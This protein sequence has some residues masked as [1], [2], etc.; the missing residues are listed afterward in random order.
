MSSASGER[1]TLDRYVFQFVDER[2][3]R[4]EITKATRKNFVSTLRGFSDVVGARPLERLGPRDVERW[5]E[6]TTRVAASTRRTM[7][8]RVKAFARWL[9]ARKL[10]RLDLMAGVQVPKVPRSV[11]RAMTAVD[12]GRVVAMAP[13]ARGRAIVA[14]LVGMGLR[15][16]EVARL[17]SG[18]W[19][20]ESETV[21]VRG[22]AGHERV[23]PVPEIVVTALEEYLD[24]W[25][26]RR[27]PLIRSYNDHGS[28]LTAAAISRY[29]SEWMGD[30]GVKHHAHDGVSAHA[31]RHTA[32]SDVLDRCG[33]LRVVQAMLGHEH[34]SST[35]IYLRRAAIGEMREAMEGR[36]YADVA[37]KSRSALETPNSPTS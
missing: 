32:A 26:M 22:K 15:C 1:R 33:D 34:L 31:L 30:A 16:V 28:P 18:D 29:V 4:G 2:A 7:F 3:A 25:P 23:L 17:Q 5:L 24:E 12:V 8:T 35:S 37:S 10:V 9:L 19:E 13:D 21:T 36:D 6:S 11:P 27:G 20:R 14:L